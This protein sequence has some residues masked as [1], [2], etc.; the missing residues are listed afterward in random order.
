MSK[1]E[2]VI[3]GLKNEMI[4]LTEIVDKTRK[5]LITLR[6]SLNAY[7]N[8]QYTEIK[9]MEE[10]GE[11]GDYSG[12]FHNDHDEIESSVIKKAEDHYNTYFKDSVY[13]RGKKLS[14]W[15]HTARSG[16]RIVRIWETDQ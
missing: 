6:S 3:Q 13:H 9:V 14:L 8:R 12:T 4:E 15:L 16:K 1:N 7:I 10:D 11:W 5:E 2:H